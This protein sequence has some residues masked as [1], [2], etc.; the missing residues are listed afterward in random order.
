[1]SDIPRVSVLTSVFNG[2]RFLRQAIE[3]VL[4]QTWRDFEYILVDDASTDRTPEIIAQYAAQDGR[5]VPLRCDTNGG[6]NR[7]LNRGL[8]LARGK[9][10]ANLDHDDIALPERLSRQVAFLDE[11]PNIGVLGSAARLIDETDREQGQTQYLQAPGALR[12][13][14]LFRCSILHSAA[15]MNRALVAQAGGYSPDHPLAT[16]YEL[17]WR[18]LTRTD[19]ANLP[20]VLVAYRKNSTQTSQARWRVQHGEVILMLYAMYKKHL[21]IQAQFRALEALY[22]FLRGAVLEEQEEV[23]GAAVLLEILYQKY[24]QQQS[25]DA[26]TLAYIRTD[27]AYKLFKLAHDHKALVPGRYDEWRARAEALDPTLLSRP[28]IQKLV[29]GG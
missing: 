23:E 24:L 3:S 25:P 2:E 22:G 1:M 7:A 27:Y 28:L 16:E 19:F 6:T 12:W 14:F 17:F 20:D 11:H 5:I 13:D 8:E 18:L 26:E 29:S 10:V 21:G 4:A 15:C 9:Y